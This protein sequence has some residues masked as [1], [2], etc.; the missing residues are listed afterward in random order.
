MIIFM[1][2]WKNHYFKQSDS[3]LC[4]QS[5]YSLDAKSNPKDQNFL[6]KVKNQYLKE[7][8]KKIQLNKKH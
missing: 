7:L 2:D 5:T 1:H 4:F 3:N 6:K 8:K